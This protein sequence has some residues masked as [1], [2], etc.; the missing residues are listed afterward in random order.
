[1][2]PLTKKTLAVGSGKGGVGKTTTA[3]NIALLCASRGMRTALVD[4]DPF[5]NVAVA[6]DIDRRRIEPFAETFADVGSGFEKNRLRAFAGLDIVFPAA[7]LEG[8]ETA[9]RISERYAEFEGA[10]RSEYDLVVLDLPA[11]NTIQAGNDILGMAGGLLMVTNAEPTSHVASGAYLRDVLKNH[12]EL[13]VYLWHNKYRARFTENFDPAD[14]VGNYNRNVAEEHRIPDGKAV[15]DLA[16]I[17]EDRAM[18]LLQSSASV[19][20]H[21][22]MAVLDVLEALQ[23]EYR[24]TILGAWKMSEPRRVATRTR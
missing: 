3:V 14:V 12:P 5:S 20:T 21:A 19:A 24:R 6:L 9:Q 11:G 18:D 10:I 8:P 1:M 16:F 2:K 15:R 23:G 7:K 17:P 13:A 4:T 22:R